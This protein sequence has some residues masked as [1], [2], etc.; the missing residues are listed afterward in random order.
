[1]KNALIRLAVD[2]AVSTIKDKDIKQA[3]E[4]FMQSNVV[5]G[6]INEAIVAGKSISTDA[7]ELFEVLR[8]TWNGDNIQ[9]PSEFTA[10]CNK[11]EFTPDSNSV[12]PMSPDD[13]A[14]KPMTPHVGKPKLTD[15]ENKFFNNI[16]K[17]S[18]IESPSHM[19]KIDISEVMK[20]ANTVVNPKSIKLEMIKK[21]IAECVNLLTERELFILISGELVDEQKFFDFTESLKKVIEDDT[22]SSN[23]LDHVKTAN[24]VLH[25]C[26]GHLITDYSS[27]DLLI[28]AYKAN[29]ASFL[30]FSENEQSLPTAQVLLSTCNMLQE[31]IKT[32]IH[33]QLQYYINS[34][35]A[36][37]NDKS[38]RLG[39]SPSKKKGGRISP[40]YAYLTRE[41]FNLYKELDNVKNNY[42]ELTN[43]DIMILGKIMLNYNNGNG[44]ITE[45]ELNF[46][47]EKKLFGIK[48]LMTES[49]DF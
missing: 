9:N 7:R 31:S 32:I 22:N 11:P 46:L 8:K 13:S 29:M 17:K 48:S 6:K 42:V 47:I 23:L 35:L 2:Y 41:I 10:P 21:N 3:T 25:Y 39:N 1:M 27:A 19:V 37:L 44:D 24:Y 49:P 45:D 30:S 5:N 26:K 34:Q 18:E 15:E 28:S 16:V 33:T 38:I 40:I 4:N 20:Q 43:N 14:V 12:K 36:T